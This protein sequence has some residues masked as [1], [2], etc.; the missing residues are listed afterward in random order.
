MG[1]AVWV[2]SFRVTKK[3][4][5]QRRQTRKVWPNPP[6]DRVNDAFR[7]SL[8]LSASVGEFSLS[9][10]AGQ[11]RRRRSRR[12]PLPLGQRRPAS[13]ARIIYLI[14]NQ[15]ILRCVPVFFLF[16]ALIIVHTPSSSTGSLCSLASRAP[17]SISP[18][19]AYAGNPEEDGGEE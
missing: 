19:R 1:T 4:A 9:A 16:S 2:S 13:A 5:P 15:F 7:P 14:S 12:Q 10:F 6:S 11:G 3:S 8:S 17:A 18:E